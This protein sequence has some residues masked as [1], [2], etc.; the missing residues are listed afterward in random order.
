MAGEQLA[1]GTTGADIEAALEAEGQGWRV[2]EAEAEMKVEAATD[3]GSD[4]AAASA[5][6][7]AVEEATLEAGSK[8]WVPKALY[9]GDPA[10]WVDA[11]TF[12]QRG[13]KFNINLQKEVAAMRKQLADFEGTRKAFVKFH[14]ETLAAKDA[15]FAAAIKELRLQRVE[16]L[17]DGEDEHVLKLEDQIDTVKAHQAALKK[18]ATTPVAAATPQASP[19]LAEW[20]EDG[21]SWF[22]S[23]PKLRDYAVA[24]GDAMVENGEKLRGRAFLDLVA[25]QVQADFP[26]KFRQAAGARPAGVEGSASG[27]L[28][29]TASVGGKSERDLPKEDRALMNQFISEGWTTKEKFLATYFAK[30]K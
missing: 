30:A 28:A 9:K 8:G 13:E 1:A 19:V 25:K 2:A 10:K 14:E 4:T 16:A 18:E 6:A 21:N 26:R 11:K 27:S 23:D 15:E 17:R 5:E 12:L 22:E 7:L 29:A 24:I 20:V 3:S